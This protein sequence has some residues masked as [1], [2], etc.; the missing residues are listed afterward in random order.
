[1]DNISYLGP[2]ELIEVFGLIPNDGRWND[3]YACFI[4]THHPHTTIPGH[5]MI[6]EGK[7][8][9]EYSNSAYSVPSAKDLLMCSDEIPAL[10]SHITITEKD[11][12]L[13]K[14]ARL[15]FL[16]PESPLLKRYSLGGLHMKSEKEMFKLFMLITTAFDYAREDSGKI[17]QVMHWPENIPLPDIEY[18][19]SIIS[20]FDQEF[21]RLEQK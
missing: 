4:P 8:L 11:P 3:I 2:D 1:M 7:I 12:E 16:N 20:A 6:K 18:Y 5:V 10:W 17:V 9:P 14:L 19:Q 13:V 21:K 15:D